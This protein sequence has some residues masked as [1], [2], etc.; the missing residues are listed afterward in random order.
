MIE[1]ILGIASSRKTS[2]A[3]VSEK[4]QQ[5]VNI[6]GKHA[7]ALSTRDSATITL[8]SKSII[9]SSDNEVKNNAKKGDYGFEAVKLVD[10]SKIPKYG[11]LDL[12]KT[13]VEADN[14]VSGY[15]LDVY[16]DGSKGVATIRLYDDENNVMY[17]WFDTTGHKPYFLTDLPPDK[18]QGVRDVV[19]H[20]GFDH[21]ETVEKFD[22]LRW[23]KRR[24]TKIV[25]KTP[26]IVR[27]LRDKV[28]RAWE[29]NIKYHHNYIYDLQLIPGM[30]YRVAG[31]KLE[32]IEFE[33]GEEE[34]RKIAEAFK[35]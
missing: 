33:V 24:V 15:L 16:Y 35:D 18:I 25:V 10:I 27:V 13:L 5:D 2:V 8:T 30:K 7:D 23:T 19:S 17:V 12:V 14:G 1:E 6:V 9:K 21:L 32:P 34:K 11:N 29:A 26:D 4:S 20:P 31:K 3:T 28:P 22:L